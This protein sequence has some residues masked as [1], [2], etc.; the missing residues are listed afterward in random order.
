MRV[1]LSS[2]VHG[3]SLALNPFS[4]HCTHVNTL[5]CRH[6]LAHTDRFPAIGIPAGLLV[7]PRVFLVEASLCDVTSGTY[8]LIL[9]GVEYLELRSGKKILWPSLWLLYRNV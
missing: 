2:A 8:A 9:G 4:K 5:L 6:R 7:V 1:F 3:A